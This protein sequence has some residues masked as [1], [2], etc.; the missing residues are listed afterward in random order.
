MADV[1]FRYISSEEDSGR[2]LDF[3]FRMGDIV[4]STR[5]KSG[6]T[7]MQMIC[8]LLVFGTPEL[9]EPLGRL[10]PWFDHLVEPRGTLVERLERQS[11]RR[12]IKT[13]TPLDGIP[14]DPRADYLVV[15]RHPLDMAVSL[16]HQGDNIDRQ[17]LAEL[18]GSSEPITRSGTRPSAHEWLLKWVGADDDPRTTMDSLAGVMWHLSDAWGRRDEP[19]V[20]LVHYDDLSADLDGQMRRIAEQ[21][22]VTIEDSTWSNLVRAASFEQMRTHAAELI[23]NSGGILKDDRAFF[24]R[25]RSGAGRELLNDEEMSAYYHRVSALAAPDLLNWLH[26]NIPS[27]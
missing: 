2:W 22:G 15:A 10:S 24:R 3:P 20:T 16:Y 23:P 7:W 6:T 8:A 25:G 5:S 14:I 4:V 17:R 13:H 11:W 27:P 9:P 1:P 18:I 21:L 19:N 26:R 12:I